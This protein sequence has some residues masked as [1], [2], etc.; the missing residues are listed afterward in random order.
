MM[1]VPCCS[2]SSCQRPGVERCERRRVGPA[3]P[4]HVAQTGPWSGRQGLAAAP[5]G[6]RERD[7]KGAIIAHHLH[8]ND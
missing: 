3:P 5:S 4:R 2:A 7:R 6:A 8:Y 1:L